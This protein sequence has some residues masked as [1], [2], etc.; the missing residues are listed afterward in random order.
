MATTAALAMILLST[1]FLS[2]ES[3]VQSRHPDQPL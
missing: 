3:L 1:W 2:F